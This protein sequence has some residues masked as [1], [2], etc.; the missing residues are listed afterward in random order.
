LPFDKRQRAA[1]PRVRLCFQR[2]QQLTLLVVVQLTVDQSIN[3][4]L[5]IAGIVL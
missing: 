1:T 5:Q 3:P 2:Q 4:A